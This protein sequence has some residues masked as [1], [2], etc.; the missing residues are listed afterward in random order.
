MTSIDITPKQKELIA[1][2]EQL[3]D[4]D[5]EDWCERHDRKPT[6]YSASDFIDE[7]MDEYRRELG[8]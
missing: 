3:L 4:V 7:H 2:I 5:F 8:F 6:K 1:K